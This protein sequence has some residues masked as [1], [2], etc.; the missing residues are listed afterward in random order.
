MRWHIFAVCG[1][2]LLLGLKPEKTA[3]FEGPWAVDGFMEHIQSLKIVSCPGLLE[4]KQ[5]R[6]I[7]ASVNG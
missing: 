2:V 6:P 7:E 5:L 1:V 3:T 4:V